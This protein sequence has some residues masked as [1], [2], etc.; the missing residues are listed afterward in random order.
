MNNE[1]T[2]ILKNPHWENFCDEDNSYMNC[3]STAGGLLVLEHQL[4]LQVFCLIFGFF[5]GNGCG[6]SGANFTL[7]F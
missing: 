7:N 5:K 6:G 3:Q 2:K 4:S 1:W